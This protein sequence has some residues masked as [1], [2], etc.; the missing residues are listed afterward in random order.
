VVV[1][2]GLESRLMESESAPAVDLVHESYW[3]ERMA[4][5]PAFIGIWG[6]FQEMASDS[7][8]AQEGLRWVI[9]QVT[10]FLPRR[11]AL[12]IEWCLILVL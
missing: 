10:T 4:V 11:S 3:Q 6:H 8:L 5:S 12:S 2:C 7:H 9:V 1:M